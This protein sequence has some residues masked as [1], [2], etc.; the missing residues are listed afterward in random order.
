[1]NH[2]IASYYI[3]LVLVTIILLW[4]LRLV[5]AALM[6]K[7]APGELPLVHSILS[8]PPTTPQAGDTEYK[9]SFSRTAGTI[10]AIGLAAVFIGVGYWVLFALFFQSEKLTLLQDVGWYFL[11]GSALFIPYAFNQLTRVFKIS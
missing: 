7:P 9:G 5:S 8:E 6:Q 3:I 2:R 11:A 1:M 4:G 10:G